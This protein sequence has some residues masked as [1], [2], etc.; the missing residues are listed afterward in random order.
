MGQLRKQEF[1]YN[2]QYLKKSIDTFVIFH[3]SYLLR[4]PS[5]KKT[6]WFDIQRIYDF[7][8]KI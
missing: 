3:P 6:M 4:Q 2:N 1:K 7:Y 8:K 5:Q